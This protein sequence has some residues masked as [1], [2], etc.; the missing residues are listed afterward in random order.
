MKDYVTAN[1]RMPETLTEALKLKAINEHQ[2]VSPLIREAMELSLG[3]EKSPTPSAPWVQESD[4]LDGI[5]GIAHSGLTDGS[6]NHDHYLYGTPQR[7][8]KKK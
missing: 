3:K 1:L 5:T 4:P 2:R 6:A 8:P 7:F